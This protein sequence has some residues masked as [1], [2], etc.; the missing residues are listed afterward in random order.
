MPLSVPLVL[1]PGHPDRFYTVHVH[2]VRWTADAVTG[3]LA[4]DPFEPLEASAREGLRMVS[5]CIAAE[6][7][8]ADVT[9]AQY[10]DG[11]AQ[12]VAR[13]LCDSDVC[14]AVAEQ[15]H[16]DADEDV[17]AEAARAWAAA[18]LQG[19]TVELLKL[20]SELEKAT[21]GKTVTSAKDMLAAVLAV[22]QERTGGSTDRVM[23]MLDEAAFL[24]RENDLFTDRSPEG[25][26][27]EL[28]R[29][30]RQNRAPYPIESGGEEKTRLVDVD[31]SADLT[32]WATPSAEAVAIPER[33]LTADQDARDMEQERADAAVQDANLARLSQSDPDAARIFRPGIFTAQL[34]AAGD[35]IG[36]GAALELYAAAKRDQGRMELF[37]A[38]SAGTTAEDSQ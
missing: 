33:Q 23:L 29:L 28:N 6:L 22:Q 9:V 4:A 38:L 13:V 26:R 27:R 21:P 14:A 10:P 5:E 2:R 8:D 20:R 24:F 18:Q 12:A 3:P 16:R 7:A 31:G 36:L 30:I 11:S 19:Q 17:E 1:T 35:D 34:N 25:V 15:Y 32:A 37:H